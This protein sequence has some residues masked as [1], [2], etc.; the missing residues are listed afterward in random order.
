MVEMGKAEFLVEGKAYKIPGRTLSGWVT[1]MYKKDRDASSVAG[2][3]VN[4]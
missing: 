1:C 2:I 3:L 4:K